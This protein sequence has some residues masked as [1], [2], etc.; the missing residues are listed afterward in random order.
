MTDPRPGGGAL[1]ATALALNDAVDD[2]AE[3][4]TTS[5]GDAVELMSV[6]LSDESPERGEG[7]FQCKYVFKCNGYHSSTGMYQ[8]SQLT[9]KNLP[10]GRQPKDSYR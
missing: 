5:S 9:R 4:V 7:D 3:I 1:A 10:A 6:A 8:V 2:A